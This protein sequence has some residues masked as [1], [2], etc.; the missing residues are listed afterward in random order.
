MRPSFGVV[1]SSPPPSPN[2][3]LSSPLPCT[4]LASNQT[5]EFHFPSVKHPHGDVS[6][7]V[8][9]RGNPRKTAIPSRFPGALG[10]W[11]FKVHTIDTSVD[12][13]AHISAPVGTL[14][15]HWL[16]LHHAWHMGTGTWHMEGWQH[17][18]GTCGPHSFESKFHLCPA[19]DRHICSCQ[20][21]RRL[22]APRKSAS[23]R[24][25]SHRLGIQVGDLAHPAGA[26][27]GAGGWCCVTNHHTSLHHLQTF[28]RCVFSFWKG[29]G[30]EEKK[31]IFF[32]KKKGQ[33]KGN[34]ERPLPV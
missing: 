14:R 30:G 18:P 17:F 22:F 2:P 7:H 32:F 15:T 8:L 23:S 28:L 10:I 24:V 21:D 19:P 11:S 13:D 26:A 34:L 1:V 27:T 6:S 4:F 3:H 33:G 12:L 9:E 20:C 16:P 31:R 25:T 5:S 29:Q